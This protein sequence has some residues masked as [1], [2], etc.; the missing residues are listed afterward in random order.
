[1]LN[2]LLR[3]YK[4]SKLLD[5]VK[6]SKQELDL[7]LYMDNIF[8]NLEEKENG[9]YNKYVGQIIFET[10]IDDYGEYENS[11]INSNIFRE[12]RKLV[13]AVCGSDETYR[14]D[15][16]TSSNNTYNII[17]LWVEYAGYT[18]VDIYCTYT[19]DI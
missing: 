1:M 9:Y 14:L 11:R 5:N 18:N 13:I 19:P 15:F 4:L 6:L 8:C 16:K 10:Y 2:G 3:K 12:I 17:D 7:C